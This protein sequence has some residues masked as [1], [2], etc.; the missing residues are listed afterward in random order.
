MIAVFRDTLRDGDMANLQKAVAS[1]YQTANRTNP[2]RL[3]VLAGNDIQLAG[4]FQT[5]SQLQAALAEVAAAAATGQAVTPAR[6][7]T[8]LGT[9]APQLGSNW[10]TVVL[11][12]HFPEIAPELAAYTEGWLSVK[13][14]SARFRVSYWDPSGAPAEVLDALTAGTGGRKLA[15]GLAVLAASLKQKEEFREAVWRD[16]APASGFRACPV[17]FVLSGNDGPADVTV[18]ALAA[19]PGTTPPD[20]EHYAVLRQKIESLAASLKQPQLSASQATQAEADLQS[21]MEIDPR[22]EETLRL[23]AALHQRQG[24]DRKLAPLLATLTEIAPHDAAVF[25]GL[26]HARYRLGDAEGADRALLRAREL[27]PGDV[28]VSEEL[29]RI[30]LARQNDREALPFLEECLAGRS[31]VQEL[32]L[33]RADVAARLNDWQRIADSLEHAIALGAVPLARRT[34]LV[35]LYLEHKM[36]DQ[37]LV[38]VRA[39]AEHL[40]PDGAVRSEYAGFLDRM[41]Q[42]DEALASWKRA[43]EADPALEP[44][45]ARIT[46]LLIDRNALGEALETAEKGIQAAPKSAR[47]YLAKAEA[48][49]KQDRFYDARRTLRQVAAALPDMALLERLAEMEDAGGGHAARY[50]RQAVEAA[51]ASG[52]ADSRTKADL[53]RG[54]AAA[55]RDGDADHAAWFRARLENP[56]APAAK[57]RSRGGTVLVPGGLAALSF[58][59]HSRSSTPDRFLVEYARTVA[60]NI[61]ATNK[62][63]TDAIHEH[64]RRIADLTALGTPKAGGATVMIALEDKKLARNGEKVLELLG[65]KVHTNREGVKVE[66]AEKGARAAHQETASALA[67][68]EIGMQ[69]KL[70]SRQPF[71]FEIPTESASVALGEEPWRAQFYPKEKYIGGLVEAMASDLRLAQTYAAVGQMDADTAAVLTAAVPLKTLAE[72]YASMLMQ[73]SS[74]LAV[75]RGRAAVPG[76]AAA[77]AIWTGLVGAGPGQPGPFFRALLARDDGKLLAF[78]G[79]LSTLDIEHQRFFTRTASRCSKFYQLYKESPEIQRAAARHIPTSP[80]EGFL[81]EVPLNPD[82]TVDFPGSP[83]VWMVAKGQSHSIEHVGKLLKRAKRSVAPDVEDEILLRLGGTRYKDAGAVRGELDNFL[84]VVHID[85]HRSEPLDESSALMLAQHF[86][87]DGASYPFF[88]A[89]TGL[90]PKQFEDFFALTEALR[91]RPEGERGADLAPLNSLIEIVCLAQ[92]TGTLDQ[93]RSAELFGRIVK[94]FQQVA[95]PA[96]RTSTSLDLVRQILALAG[97][98]A[99]EPDTAMRKLL[100]GSYPAATVELDGE[101][102]TLDPSKARHARYQQVLE[103]QKVPSLATVLALSDAARKIGSGKG[104]PA[105]Q[106]QVLD[107]KAAGLFYIGVPKELQMKAPER[108]LVQGF[109]PRRLQEIVKQ[110]R[111]KTAKKKVDLK[112]LEKL[113]TEYLDSMDA[114]VRWALAGIVYA[115]FLSPDDLLVSEDSLLLRKHRFVT[116]TPGRGTPVWQIAELKQT[117]EKGGSSFAG[118]FAGFADAAG[119]AAAL[120]GK[121]GGENG[122]LIAGKQLGSIRMTN[123]AGLRD[124][125]LRLMGLKVT[126]AREWVARAASQPEVES[127]LAEATLGLLSLTRRAGLLTALGEGNWKSVWDALTLADLY[128]LGDRYLESYP[129]DAWQSPATRALRQIAAQNDGSRLQLLG[130]ELGDTLGCSHPHLRSAP[131]YEE[132]EKDLIPTRLA[133]RTAEFKLY[134]A[135]YADEEGIPASALGALAEPAARG[136]LKKFQ[137]SDIHDWRSVLST[138]AT[139]DR[140]AIDGGLVK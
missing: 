52:A 113:G 16:P 41:D 39:V 86:A 73:Y 98:D 131:P 10:S 70:E 139:L 129:K 107:S 48:L 40:P 26:G 140:K 36:P 22:G 82:G 65:W 77:D 27:K 102:I 9:A 44:A 34:A 6:F 104:P 96:Q 53:E 101:S 2:L 75:E 109:Q 7:Y 11:V 32:W 57:A 120:S 23:G 3:A 91:S 89:L 30:R 29:A 119:T 94:A 134:L 103:L 123:W 63:F 118:S 13:L 24:N 43:L 19:A 14:R 100:L 64:F 54:L 81:A 105:E 68:D 87:S 106:I 20:P 45:Y 127:S 80:F 69:E 115:W 125:D 84:A 18:P 92:Q 90:G 132:Y 28:A 128:F 138:F 66:P 111:E 136:M 5:R 33:V 15:D 71:S 51:G 37:A 130:G 112:D 121:L 133:E 88:A 1:F 8:G 74:A 49:D 42:P 21:A 59:A 99:A 126:V 93:A 61:V 56:G 135:R 124:Q 108:D 117:S 95:S 85:E 4:P 55:L 97:L 47:L 17:T 122:E 72:K 83:E 58:V 25:A 62:R 79:A 116:P 137:L 31:N 50:Y 110:L 35:R 76:G 60:T 78:Y 114:P 12:G 67:I 38:H 46:R